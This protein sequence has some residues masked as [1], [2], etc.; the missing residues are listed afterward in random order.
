M[1]RTLRVLPCPRGD[2]G[3]GIRAIVSE[4]GELGDGAPW[5]RLNLL[6]SI[7]ELRGGGVPNREGAVAAGVPGVT[8]ID[9]SLAFSEPIKELD[10]LP[11][12]IGPSTLREGRAGVTAGDDTKLRRG[13]MG[14]GVRGVCV[15]SGLR[16]EAPVTS[17]SIPYFTLLSRPM[18]SPINSL[19]RMAASFAAFSALGG[20]G[21][22]P[23]NCNAEDASPSVINRVTTRSYNMMS[24]VGVLRRF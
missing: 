22:W 12:E 13:A 24:E 18:A 5:E 19:R 7:I 16:E 4:A 17:I 23:S 21:N 1:V 2:D 10:C 15:S 8:W 3:W 9:G 11:P 20:M 6:K 14:R